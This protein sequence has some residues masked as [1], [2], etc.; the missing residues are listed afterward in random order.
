MSQPIKFQYRH[1]LLVNL[2]RP[3]FS[4]AV[5]EKNAA[6]LCLCLQVI[7]CIAIEPAPPYTHIYTYMS[8]KNMVW[9][10]NKNKTNITDKTNKTYN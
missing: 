8:I 10:Q 6:Y 2:Q 5:S 3:K 4:Q 9:N 7:W 1:V